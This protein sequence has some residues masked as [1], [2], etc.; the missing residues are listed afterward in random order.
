[1]IKVPTNQKQSINE[2]E[3]SIETISQNKIN[4]I[5]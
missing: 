1:M 5:F 4:W 2:L 3:H